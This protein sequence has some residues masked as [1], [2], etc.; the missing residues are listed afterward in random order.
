MDKLIPAQVITLSLQ[1]ILMD[2]ILLLTINTL[3]SSTTTNG[4]D[5]QTYSNSGNYLVHLTINS[6]SSSIT[7]INS[8][9]PVNSCEWT[10]LYQLG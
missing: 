2:V 5:S 6:T 7:T 8:C 1:Q 3:T 10:N 9:V 4:C